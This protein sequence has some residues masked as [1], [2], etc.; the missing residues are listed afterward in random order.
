MTFTAACPR[1]YLVVPAAGSGRRLPGA[2][3]KQYRE[4]AGKPVLQH[5]LERAGKLS[6]FSA[7]VVA[8]AE[9]DD[10]WPAL[11]AGLDPLVSAKLLLATGGQERTD[12]VLSALQALEAHAEE[13]DWVLVHD[14]VRPCISIEDIE[15]LISSVA[16]MSSGGLLA[17]RVRDTIKQS[18]PGELVENTVDRSRL[19]QAQTP[20]MFRY[21]ILRDALICAAKEGR[22]ITD[23]ASAVEALGLPVRLVKGHPHNIKVTWE[24]DLALATMLLGADRQ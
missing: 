18:G 7:V 3:P 13:D 9:N 15:F 6:V 2:C 1:Y 5:T 8:L 24:E 19:W 4:V 21:G 16:D 11:Q 10:R 23:E 12:S 17:L 20:Q 22:A 14:A